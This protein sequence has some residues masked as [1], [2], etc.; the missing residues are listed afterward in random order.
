M[1]SPSDT[2]AS[3]HLVRNGAF[4]V[5]AVAADEESAG[6][7]A[8]FKD[9]NSK[10]KST[11]RQREDLEEHIQ[12]LDAQ[13]EQADNGVDRRVESFELG[14]LAYVDKNRAH[15]KYILY[16]PLGLRDVT[17]A[18]KRTIQPAKVEVLLKTMG[19]ELALPS[20]VGEYKD[21]LLMHQGP[22]G[23]RQALVKPVLEALKA[24][25]DEAD[26][27]DNVVIPGLRRAWITARIQLHG[28]LTQKFPLDKA[29]VESYF[30]RFRRR[31]TKAGDDG[32][33]PGVSGG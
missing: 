26:Y 8:D 6:M 19:T 7:E 17:Q 9:H 4:T 10:L 23:A 32:G 33:T 11:L 15:S 24:A 20:T 29:R 31:T 3:I 2:L 18:D 16:F 13:V 25:E 12:A 30:Q 21:L 28:A 14:L 22:L 1:D 27:L 5:S